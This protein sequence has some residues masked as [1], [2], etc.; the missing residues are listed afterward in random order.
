MKKKPTTDVNYFYSICLDDTLIKSLNAQIP[1]TVEFNNERSYLFARGYKSDSVNLNNDSLPKML[2]I[3][4]AKHNLNKQKK[5]CLHV[6]IG[7]AKKILS[8]IFISTVKT[9][10]KIRQNA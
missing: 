9:Q 3:L 4:L 1:L 6:H 10:I 7:H 5:S 8:R 2:D